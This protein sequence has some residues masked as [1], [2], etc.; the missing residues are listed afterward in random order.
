MTKHFLKLL[1]AFILVITVSGC[2]KDSD[3]NLHNS[4]NN[5]NLGVSSNDLLS[6]EKYT[7]LKLEVAYVKDYEPSPSTLNNIKSFLEEHINKPNGISLV[8]KEIQSTGSGPFSIEQVK[9]I[10][11]ET[12]TSFNSGN[13]ISVYLLFL[14]GKS[15]SQKDNKLILGTAYKNTSMVIYGETIHRL[16]ETSGIS[17]SEIE[18]TTIMHE[19]GHLFGLVD[20]GSP[21]QSD[22]EDTESKSHCNVPSCLMVATVEFGHGTLKMIEKGQAI[23][24]DESCRHD[25][26]ANGGK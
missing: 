18:S 24:F 14:N 26:R 3:E 25:L 6:D 2:T 22:H 11:D 20:N 7:S 9:K 19:F 23:G 4:S 10:E 13:K 12:R 8:T 17:K 15:D 21:A 16:S 5:L 1:F